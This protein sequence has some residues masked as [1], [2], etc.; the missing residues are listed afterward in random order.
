[1][2]VG[3]FMTKKRRIIIVAVLLI[4]A[5]LS[6]VLIYEDK[7]IQLNT[8]EIMSA[9]L[10]TE[11]DGYRIAHVS[12]F[13]NATFGEDNAK[14]INMLEES[15][16]D[17]IA[18][19]GDI[20]DS[21]C[22]DIDISF[23]FVEEILK[24]APCYYVT[25]NHEARVSEEY[26]LL[27]ERM[28]QS[29]VIILENNSL[30]IESEDAFIE[31]IGLEDPTFSVIGTTAEEADVV[32]DMLSKLIT[33]DT[34]FTLLLSHKPEF[35][36]IY[37]ENDVDLVLSGHTHG[38]QFRIPFIG[39]LIAPGQGLFPELDSGLFEKDGT[40]MI[41]S[42]G[43]GNSIIPLRINNRPEIILIDLHSAG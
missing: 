37:A 31:I 14:L 15:K 35:F 9:D 22:T 20:I 4:V 32:S 23:A 39:G 36:D 5:V 25:G 38:G 21:R 13:H 26:A 19:T 41:V 10:P 28:V 30:F 18:I 27:R 40:K 42:R 6:C 1:M 11:F 8:F 33:A 12:D 29:G 43:I 24:I 34:D 2:K 17:I 7:N 16:P 3:C